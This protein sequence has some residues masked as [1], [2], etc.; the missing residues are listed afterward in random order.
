VYTYKC[1]EYIK[2]YVL[3]IHWVHRFCRHVV[4]LKMDI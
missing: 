2:Y 3:T 4:Y 1:T